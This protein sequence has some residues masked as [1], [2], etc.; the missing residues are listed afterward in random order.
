MHKK[1]PL[2]TS[3]GSKLG[4]ARGLSKNSLKHKKHKKH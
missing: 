3:K 4:N 2:T 1:T